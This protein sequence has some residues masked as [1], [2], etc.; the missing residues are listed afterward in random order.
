MQIFETQ[1]FIYLQYHSPPRP[2]HHEPGVGTCDWRV[3]LSILCHIL[4]KECAC[5]YQQTSL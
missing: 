1:P 4:W 2:L 3:P 5:W